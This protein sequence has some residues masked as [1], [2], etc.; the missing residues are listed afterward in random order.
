[1]IIILLRCVCFAVLPGA[2]AESRDEWLPIVNVL[3]K[4]MDCVCA[5]LYLDSIAKPWVV[6]D[7][8][9]IIET[10]VFH[11]TLRANRAILLGKSFGGLLAHEYAIHYPK[12]IIALVLFAPASN[13]RNRIQR[14]CTISPP[15][16]IFLGWTGDDL[17]YS[18]HLKFQHHCKSKVFKFYRELY[19]GHEIMKE[20]HAPIFEFL[21]NYTYPKKIKLHF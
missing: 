14:L 5:I 3:V 6:K 4:K 20:Y 15:I 18:H 21:S 13:D 10:H 11:N 2:A 19:G 17:S 1:M 8:L 7:I 16:P 12:H 9:E